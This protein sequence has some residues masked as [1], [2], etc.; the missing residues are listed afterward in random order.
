MVSAAGVICR[1]RIPTSIWQ[2]NMLDAAAG[3]DWL[4]TAASSSSPFLPLNSIT[5]RRRPRS[6]RTRRF[7]PT[8]PFSPSRAPCMLLFTFVTRR[9]DKATTRTTTHE[10]HA[11]ILPRLTYGAVVKTSR[12]RGKHEAPKLSKLQSQQRSD[13]NPVANP[14]TRPRPFLKFCL[15]D[16][17]SSA[18]SDEIAACRTA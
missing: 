8:R 15:Q 18:A 13:F 11:P 12:G 2:P 9:P 3:R 17:K 4:S 7:P 5:S 1:H 6:E 16:H 10:P 14:H